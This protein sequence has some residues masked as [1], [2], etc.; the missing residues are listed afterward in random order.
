MGMGYGYGYVLW[1]W[2]MCMGMGVHYKYA[3]NVSYRSDIIFVS[4]QPEGL[5]F[6][7]D[8][9]TLR[10]NKCITLVQRTS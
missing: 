10:L 9:V 5:E 2:I 8:L 1:V 3:G 4:P 7:K 6:Q